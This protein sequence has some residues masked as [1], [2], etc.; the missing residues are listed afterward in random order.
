MVEKSFT[1]NFNCKLDLLMYPLDHQTCM[2]EIKPDKN[3][4]H[5]ISLIPMRL[6][7]DGGSDSVNQ[8][9]ISKWAFKE[10]TK[11]MIIIRIE[12]KRQQMYYILN[13]ILPIILI[14]VV[15]FYFQLLNQ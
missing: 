6:T 5:A 1:V 4:G 7:F 14:N 3:N 2:I 12:F 13:V 11:N 10:T 8:Y 15:G 9:E